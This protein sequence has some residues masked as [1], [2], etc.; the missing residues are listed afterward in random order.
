MR[1]PL[2]TAVAAAPLILL[3]GLGAR[4]ETTISNA[5]TTPVKTSTANNGQPDDV[6]V[7]SGGSITVSGPVAATLDSNNKLT[8]NGSITIKDQDNSTGV[9]ILG[10]HTGEFDLGGSIGMDSSY[11]AKDA[12]NDGVP[13]GDYAQGTGRYAVRLTGPAAF[14]GSLNLGSTSIINV[15]GNNSFGVSTEAPIVGNLLANGAITVIGDNTTGIN[16]AGGVSG[17]TTI[18]GAVSATGAGAQGAVYSGNVGGSL[19]V[20][21]AVQSTGYRITTRPSDPAI[22]ANF[23]ASDI[24]QSGSALSV[25]ANVG[26]GL[27]VGAPP[28][29]TSTTDTTTDADN[30]GI[31]D[32]LEGS[33]NITTFSGAP[34]LSIGASGR[35]VSLGAFGAGKNAYGLIIEG[36]VSGQGVYDNVA[37]TAVQ[38][39]AAGGTVHVAGGARLVGTVSASAYQADATGLHIGAGSQVPALVNEGS[40]SVGVTSSLASTATGVLIDAGGAVTSLNNS[41]TIGA[42]AI[43]DSGS[44]YVVRD[45]SGLLSNIVNT[46]VLATSITPEHSGDSTTGRQVALDL[47]ANTSGVTL[48]QGPN[49]N[50]AVT[51]AIVGDI[52]LGSGDDSVSLQ[53]G[54]V[55]GALAFGAGKASLTVDNGA[56]FAGAL[57]SSGSMTLNVNNGSVEDDSA[58]T[59]NASSLTVGAKGT[60]IISADPANNQATRFNVSGPATLAS[61]AQLGLHLNSL[62]TGPTTFT[63]ISSP[64][65]TVGAT[66][67]S[68]AGETPYLF[69]ASFHADQAAGVVDLNLRRRTAAEAGLNPA[70]AA[71]FDPV[72]SSLAG[73]AGIQRAFLAQ[74]DQS[75]LSTMVNQMLPDYAGGVFRALSWASEQE[76]QA[77]GD[78][79]LGQQR[80]G[81]TRAWTQEI[82]LHEQKD[83]A[84]AAG[85]DIFGIGAVGGFESVSAKGD[86]LGV[87]FGFLSANIKNP[88]L[89][90]DNLLG[91]SQLNAGV[92]WRGSYGA[93]MTD[94]Q[95][96]AGYVWTRGRREFLYSDSAGVVHR[97]A[98]ADWNGYTLSARAGAQYDAELGAVFFRPR[99][100]VDYFRL[101]ESGYTETGGGSSFDLAVNGRS[102]DLLSVTGSVAAGF[103]FGQGF[104]WRPQIEGGYRAIL[105]GAAGSTTA[106]FAGGTPF[107]LAAESIRQNA[108]YGRAGVRVYSDYLD[109]LL[110]G[111]IEHASDYTDIDLQLIARTVF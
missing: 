9:M 15:A 89:P 24:Q 84:Q 16:E 21:S 18:K 66:D 44:A 58:S 78:A 104:R 39:G 37:A 55:N 65:L 11:T 41:G 49:A 108:V 87:K 17:Q 19:T 106:A 107:T 25:R 74:T 31:V 71:A 88:D 109:L 75:G 50:T 6:T 110:D 32:S 76:G 53:A 69:V 103:T 60:L 83:L 22:I 73:D 3:G 67:Q 102:G 8:V 5:S 12:N 10:G 42:A 61:G 1:K 27:F 28:A 45:N 59:I 98:L 52:L 99:V 80:Q 77:A 72:Y 93:L 7:N 70:Q 43:S 96:G 51:P 35:D 95:L 63:V 86:A 85:Y 26:G 29:G 13:D 33:G 46:G 54:S 111:G 47:G 81:P 94:L 97:T 79:P 48:V 36:K 100:H 23:P 62:P 34:A 92:Y 56:T 105:A 91:V 4:A 40:V 82:V 14:T 64:N 2:L 68:L 57:T 101:H 38:I 30:D 90:S 20:Y